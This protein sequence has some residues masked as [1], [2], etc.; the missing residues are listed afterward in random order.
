MGQ[1]AKTITSF[2]NALHALAHMNKLQETIT[3]VD[4]SAGRG[5]A[6][7]FCYQK[8]LQCADVV[9]IVFARAG[10]REQYTIIP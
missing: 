7:R 6:N 9:P 10:F 4:L 3:C 2:S 5:R 1:L 8:A